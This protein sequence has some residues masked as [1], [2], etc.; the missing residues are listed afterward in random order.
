MQPQNS[1]GSFELLQYSFHG[2]RVDSHE[3]ELSLLADSLMAF[4]SLSERAAAQICG[5]DSS[6]EVRVKGAPQAGSFEISL[7]LDW[8][9]K[10]PAEAIAAASGLLAMTGVTLIGVIKQIYRLGIWAKGKAVSVVNKGDVESTVENSD[11]EKQNYLT[12]VVNVYNMRATQRDMDKM[13]RP[14]DQEGVDAIVLDSAET[15]TLRITKGNRV[16]FQYE[17]EGIV[18]DDEAIFQLELVVANLNGE[19]QGWRFSDGEVDFSATVLD[20][21]FLEQV[22]SR[23]IVIG[24]GDSIEARLRTV[25]RRPAMRLRTER[26]VTEVLRFISAE[27]AETKQK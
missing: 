13:T 17:G 18:K 8:A 19:S 22:K 20:E 24:A 3:I 12:V 7:V 15:D 2:P 21:A 5:K 10:N 16:F 26:T 4:R 6:L 1:Q 27:N 25:Q 9:Q 23:Q 11:K 14:L